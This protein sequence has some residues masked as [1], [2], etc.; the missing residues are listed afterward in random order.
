MNNSYFII[1]QKELFLLESDNEIVINDKNIINSIQQVYE[2][3]LKSQARMKS[4][5]INKMYNCQNTNRNNQ[6]YHHEKLKIEYE[7]Q[8]YDICIKQKDFIKT[9]YDINIDSYEYIF[10]NCGMSSIFSA[11]YA[12]KKLGYDID[13]LNNIY[14][15]T[16]RLLDDYIPKLKGNKKCLFVDTLSYIPLNEV[17]KKINLNSYDIYIIDTTLY[18]SKE[19]KNIVNKFISQN[20]IL[21]LLKSHTKMDMLGCEWA[22]VG[23]IC[24]ISNNKNIL[25]ILIKE[26]RIILSII[27]GFAY[28]NSI[29][30]YWSKKEFKKITIDRNETIKKNTMYVFEKLR[31][32][33]SKLEIIKPPHNMF[34]IIKPNKFIDYKEL[35]ASLHEYCEN[36]KLSGLVN[37]ADSFGLDCFGFNGYYENMAA[38]TEVIRIS[39]SD[40]PLEICDLIIEDFVNWLEKYLELDC[41]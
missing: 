15:E 28:P 35:E 8:R 22:N 32:L 3:K 40:Y 10:T 39:P 1:K 7:Y 26:I 34:I 29:P 19:I 18:T 31:K 27:G 25:N 41:D 5:F 36:S 37:Y 20:K 11:F 16:Q 24:V 2:K 14:V 9:F 6:R 17:I 33:L 4:K 13:Y 12:L 38:E 21:I 23:S 30:L